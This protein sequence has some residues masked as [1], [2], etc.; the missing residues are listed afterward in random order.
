MNILNV[1]LLNDI[2]LG[3]ELPKSA[4][5]MFTDSL[6]PRKIIRFLILLNYCDLHYMILRNLNNC[7]P[8]PLTHLVADIINHTLIHGPCHYSRH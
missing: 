6:T 7:L 4:F 3:Y 8:H 5:D 1:K 2:R